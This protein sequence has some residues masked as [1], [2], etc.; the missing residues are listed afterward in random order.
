MKY[1]NSCYFN[2]SFVLTASCC[3]S[4]H[5]LFATTMYDHSIKSYS[6]LTPLLRIMFAGFEKKTTWIDTFDV[7]NWH[8]KKQFGQLIKNIIL[9]QFLWH[10]NCK[11][12]LNI[13]NLL[14]GMHWI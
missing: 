8:T 2:S 10:L 4:F 14:F 1:N 9:H 13:K 5:E 11:N 6:M 3:T 12:L 7:I